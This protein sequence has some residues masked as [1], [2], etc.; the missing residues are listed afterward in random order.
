[1]TL[2][3]PKEEE[4]EDGK[5]WKGK[6]DEEDDMEYYM[7]IDESTKCHN[8]FGLDSV[9]VHFK[10]KECNPAGINSQLTVTF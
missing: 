4:Q 3:N 7:C 2:K 8:I 5:R 6:A 1:M 9:Q 10:Y